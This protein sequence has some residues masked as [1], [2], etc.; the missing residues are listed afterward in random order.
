MADWVDDY[1]QRVIEKV[2]V[3]MQHLDGKTPYIL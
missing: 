1:L 3:E 2:A